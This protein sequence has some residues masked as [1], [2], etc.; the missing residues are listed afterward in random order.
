ML[1][2]DI[3]PPPCD[4]DAPT[5]AN[6]RSSLRCHCS[7]L[8]SSSPPLHTAQPRAEILPPIPTK[9]YFSSVFLPPLT[10]SLDLL[11]SSPFSLPPRPQSGKPTPC[12]IVFYGFSHPQYPPPYPV[13]SLSD[14]NFQPPTFRR[15]IPRSSLSFP[16]F[17]SQ[18]QVLHETHSALSPP[19]SHFRPARA[20][21]SHATQILPLYMYLLPR[22]FVF[23]G[24][25]F[26]CHF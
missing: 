16:T 19:L 1:W 15:S 8:F 11:S 23:I 26:S 5:L 22:S 14:L 17:C 2:N 20:Y 6:V 13:I 25:G 12:F 24:L 18:S 9:I 4:S 21:T 10:C 7:Y 3:V